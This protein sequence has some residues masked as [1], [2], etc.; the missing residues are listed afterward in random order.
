MCGRYALYGPVS[1]LG[2]HFGVSFEGFDFEPRYNV[3]PLQFAPVIR[4]NSGSRQAAMLRWGLLPSSARDPALANRL[5]NARSESA[6]EKPSFRAALRSRRCLVPVDGFYEW[7]KSGS[8]KQPFLFQLAS[9]EPMALAGLWECWKGADGEA[10]P[11]FT[12]LTIS[13]NALLAT[14]HERM[15]VILP[16]ETWGL[17]LNPSRTPQQLAPM[18][19]PYNAS[20]MTARPVSR[21]LGSPRNEGAHLLEADDPAQ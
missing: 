5:I 20:L 4:E 2:A 6:A 18:M 11:T 21:R 14:F 1:R 3:S 8:G 7:R 15:P 10:L 9:G 12:I 16:P 17:W 13:A 19:V